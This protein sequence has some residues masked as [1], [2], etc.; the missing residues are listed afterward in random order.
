MAFMLWI[1]AVVPVVSGI[2]S[3]LRSEFSR[4]SC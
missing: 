3:I 4:G 1:M 2:V